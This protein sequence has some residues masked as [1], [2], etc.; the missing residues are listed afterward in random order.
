MKLDVNV[1]NGKRGHTSFPL[2]KKDVVISNN[3][4]VLL[5]DEQVEFKL[6][7]DSY[8]HEVL[9]Y[10]N[11]IS[12]TP[13]SV[14]NS[15][16]LWIYTWTPK[17]RNNYSYEAFFF[18]Y[19]GI[20][21]IHLSLKED[22][23]S[24]VTDLIEF[25]PIEVLAKKINAERVELMLAFIAG[26]DSNA[27]LDFFR[28]TKYGSSLR[29]GNTP[30]DIFYDKLEKIVIFIENNIDKI[31]KNP[32]SKLSNTHFYSTPN[33]NTYL[34]ED[35]ISWLC[36]NADQLYEEDAGSGLL[37][38][39]DNEYGIVKIRTGILVEDTNIYE[40]QVIHGFVDSLINAL[41]VLING[42]SSPDNKMVKGLRNVDGY[43]S[44]FNQINKFYKRMNNTKLIRSK[45]MIEN[46]RKIKF[47]L[48]S[49]MPVKCNI[50]G[51]PV[52]THKV[53]YNISYSSFFIKI[54][55]WYSCGK[56]DWTIREELFSIKSIPKLFEYYVLFYMK[57]I[58]EEH[59]GVVMRN[60]SN[61]DSS[62]YAYLVND[63]HFELEYEPKYWTYGH[64]NNSSKIINSEQWSIKENKINKRSTNGPKSHRC[65]DFV[66]KITNNKGD[67][68]MYILDAKYTDNDRAFIH[69]IPE[70]TMKYIHGVH[71][72]S[73]ESIV[74]GLVIINPSDKP[75][76]RSFHNSKYDIFSDQ[77]IYP[78]IANV[79]ITPGFEFSDVTFIDKVIGRIIETTTN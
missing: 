46:L 76:M 50:K 54:A 11:D 69:Y 42:Y 59:S 13:S 5:E 41:L 66:I 36:D 71:H 57:K 14:I 62:S 52:F 38:L 72:I 51:I 75:G 68:S 2:Y 60:D 9:I 39:D 61:K 1:I 32:L 7:L 74:K 65:P 28:V 3:N 78:I 73:G 53:R 56:P 10:I 64:V 16:N 63:C 48:E 4:V 43:E 79:G 29:H 40:N 24:I 27:L 21:E 55:Q 12:M 6:T 58:I 47:K 26:H 22:E 15:N 8:F 30:V 25:H 35:S 45:I 18:N 44:F 67:L 19:F 33:E 77:P 70:L 37:V 20:A 17:R 31:I 49:A 34:D 23:S